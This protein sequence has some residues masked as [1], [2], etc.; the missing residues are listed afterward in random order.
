LR[1]PA[2]TL[3]LKRDPLGGLRPVSSVAMKCQ[4]CREQR[5]RCQSHV[6][7]LTI[8]RDGTLPIMWQD[9]TK[10]DLVEDFLREHKRAEGRVGS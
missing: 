3:Q 8:R 6:S 10:L 1:P 7:S 4:L 2:L 5:K 9:L